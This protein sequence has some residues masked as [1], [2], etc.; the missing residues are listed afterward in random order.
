M[1]RDVVASFWEAMRANDWALAAQHLT[2][3]CVIDWPCTGERIEGRERFV[4]IQ[5]QYPTATGHW[6]FDVHRIVADG[7]TVVSEVTVTDGV[8][9][10][11]LVAFSRVE[12]DLIVEQ[13]EYWPAPYDPPF[14]REHLT[15]PIDK[16]P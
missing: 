9:S 5:E 13:I 14:G 15:T 2:V 3:N 8:Q 12:G 16:I 6:A 1:A 4:A 11:R 10:A 7:E